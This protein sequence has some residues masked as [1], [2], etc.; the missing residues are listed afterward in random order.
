M[1]MPPGI[2]QTVVQK[3]AFHGVTHLS[4][5]YES[6]LGYA[7]SDSICPPGWDRKFISRSVIECVLILSGGPV[8][9]EWFE[10]WS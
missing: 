4:R 9:V 10:A 7:R 3:S 1:Y 2:P 8:R 5:H 6:C